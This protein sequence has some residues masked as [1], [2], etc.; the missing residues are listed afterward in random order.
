MRVGT[1]M[2]CPP[3]L[4]AQH[5]GRMI[6]DN[7]SVVYSPDNIPQLPAGYDDHPI[8]T[9]R[10]EQIA[11]LL[12]A[13]GLLQAT[14]F[15]Q[16]R[17]CTQQ[18]LQ[19][20]H[21]DDYLHNLH[22]LLPQALCLPAAA[23]PS[24]DQL[25]AEILTPFRRMTAGTTLAT[26]L[27]ITKGNSVHIGGGFHHAHHD[28]GHGF[29]LYG[30]I[31]LAVATIRQAGWSGKVLIVDTDAHQ[32]DGNHAFFAAD[33]SVL[34]I[35]MHRGDIFPFQKYCADVDIPVHASLDPELYLA[36]LQHHLQHAMENF[37]PDLVF[38]IAGADVLQDDPLAGLGFSAENVISR[39]LLVYN[40]CRNH[41]VPFVHLLAGGYSPNAAQVQARSIGTILIAAM[42]SRLAA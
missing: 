32:G 22:K 3:A 37:Q 26:L 11:H 14:D 1:I 9:R 19:Q 5:L 7:C 38:H 41:V 8:C 40:A 42:S 16:P 2:S 6:N 29:C 39:D 17:P 27:A 12:L 30:D 4:F 18:E 15:W 34:T 24:L 23:L 28:F 13:E 33:A 35:S 10:F 20:I 31:P 36:I 25:E 21:D